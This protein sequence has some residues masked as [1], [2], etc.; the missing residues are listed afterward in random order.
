MTIDNPRM[1]HRFAAQSVIERLLPQRR[2][3]V[4]TDSVAWLFGAKGEQVVGS[5]LD[6]LPPE[7]TVLHALPLGARNCA[8][9]HLVVGPG[10][11]FTITTKHHS[12]RVVGVGKKGMTVSGRPV[13]NM[14]TAEQEAERVTNLVRQ[15]MPLVAPVQP[16]IAVVD[17]KELIIHERPEQVK[18]IDARDLRRWLMQLQPVL[19]EPE[20]MELDSIVD[21]P[22]TWRA[23]PENAAESA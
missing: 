23:L 13:P 11:V 4:S 21:S 19:T 9:D 17:P 22:G 10:G 20:L 14:R 1:R 15:M 16:V 7:W 8:I 18:V 5:I 2:K 12:G 6:A 3:H